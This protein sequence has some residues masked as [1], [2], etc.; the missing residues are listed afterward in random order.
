MKKR[1]FSRVLALFMAV[2]LLST[3]AFAASFADLQNAINGTGGTADAPE[4]YGRDEGATEGGIAAWNQDGNRNVQLN[5]NVERKDISS[6]RFTTITV[7]GR[8]KTDVILDLNG[9][10]IINNYKEEAD[11][12]KG[13]APTVSPITVK[14]DSTSLTITDNSEKKDGAI[15]GNTQSWSS[16]IKVTD[17]AKLTLE[18]GTVKGHT[19]S[20]V[21]VE[22]DSTF[23]MT[24]GSISN[25]SKGGVVI[26]DSAFSMSNGTISE[27]NN[28][29]MG[30]GVSVNNS[31]F[32]MTGGSIIKNEAANGGGGIY[33]ASNSEIKLTGTEDNPIIISENKTTSGVNSHGAG[34]N[35]AGK[36]LDMENVLMEGNAASGS[37]GALMVMSVK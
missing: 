30:G 6:E 13:Q 14:G 8:D 21:V 1:I 7:G 19:A 22:K 18:N 15:I 34:I 23:E 2:S 20:G 28:S 29:G 26:T 31:S 32:I 5:E 9:N 16:G 27:N 24:G 33:G 25:N 11:Q 12:S 10:S 17:G 36:Q 3:T 37:G 4:Y 35:F